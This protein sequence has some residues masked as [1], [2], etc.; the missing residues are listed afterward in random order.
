MERETTIGEVNAPDVIDELTYISYSTQRALKPSI[1]PK[2]WGL[3][4]GDEQV[5][6]MEER[7]QR[8]HAR[9]EEAAR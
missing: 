3:L 8:E 6:K 1:Q 4:Y 9:V 2:M 7:Y 5:K